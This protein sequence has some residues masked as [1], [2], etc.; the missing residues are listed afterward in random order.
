MF[1]A[2][3]EEKYILAAQKLDLIYSQLGIPYE[4]LVN[5]PKLA[6]D[7]PKSTPSPHVDGVIGFVSNSMSQLTSQLGKLIVTS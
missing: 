6:I 3:N 4:V 1:R 5:A 7:P 2:F